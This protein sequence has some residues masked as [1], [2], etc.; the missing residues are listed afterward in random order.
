MPDQIRHIQNAIDFAQ[1]FGVSRETIEKLEQYEA[2]LKLWQKSKNLIANSTIND[3]WHRHF[4]DSAQL[5]QHIP[6]S[7]KNLV[8]IGSGAGFPALVLAILMQDSQAATKSF[9]N[10]ALHLVESNTKK[11][12]FLQEVARKLD[13]S[14]KSHTNSIAFVEIHNCRIETLHESAQHMSIDCVT[15][16]ALAS[17]DK[18]LGLTHP[19]LQQNTE[20]VFLKGRDTE[21]EIQNAKKIWRFEYEDCLSMTETAGTIIKI[22]N[23][24]PVMDKKS[25]F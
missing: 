19:F 21:K 4:A 22:T 12:A 6:K 18:L 7:T 11:C 3:I 24:A 10:T 1:A 9:Q 15:A 17:L 20:L 23:V 14:S 13:L 5:L 8:D 2:L 16:R 25:A